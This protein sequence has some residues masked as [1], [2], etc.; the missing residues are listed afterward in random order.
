LQSKQPD[1]N[2]ETGMPE[3]KL[4][5]IVTPCYREESNITQHFDRVRKAIQ[6]LTE[7]YSFEHI[8]MDNCSDDLTFVKIQELCR[9][10]ANVRGIRYSRNIGAD[11]SMSFGLAEAKGD[12]VILIQADL[13]DPPELIPD[14]VRHWEEGHDVVY[15]KIARRSEGAILQAVRRLYYRIIA[16]LSDVPIPENAGDFRL[17]SRRA[18]DALLQ[19]KE[20]DLY[21]RGAMALVG[22]AQKPVLFEKAPRAGGKSSVNFLYLLGYA[23]NG[24]LSTTVVPLRLV[25]LAGVFV[26]TLGF[27]LSGYIVVMKVLYPEHAPQGYT[28]VATLLT[29]FSG[30]QLL[31]LGV[32]GEYLRKIYMQSLQRPKGFIQDRV[33]LP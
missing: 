32:I 12:A 30:I 3:K 10:H 20:H 25:T 22:F 31:S 24:L 11:R 17:T 18:L 27:L 7:R 33:N 6:P 29:F 26:A 9:A 4:I 5:S 19:F 14:F 2:A 13:Q 23:I 1:D 28:T 8:Y 15:G 21:I 16:K